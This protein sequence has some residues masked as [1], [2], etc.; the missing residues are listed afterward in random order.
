M[1][2]ASQLRATTITAEHDNNYCG[3]RQ[4]LLRKATTITA[5]SDNMVFGSMCRLKITTKII[6]FEFFSR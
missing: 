2:G 5:E 4:Q 6:F 3:T 1:G